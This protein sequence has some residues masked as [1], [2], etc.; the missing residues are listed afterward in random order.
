MTDKEVILGKTIE[1]KQT[2]A[3]RGTEAVTVEQGAT[4]ALVPFGHH[5]A[6]DGAINWELR[7]SASIPNLN[8][9]FQIDRFVWHYLKNNMRDRVLRAL[10]LSNYNTAKTVNAT[11]SAR[12]KF[13]RTL[14]SAL[15]T[16]KREFDKIVKTLEQYINKPARMSLTSFLIKPITVM[17][18]AVST[19]L[20]L[21]KEWRDRGDWEVEYKYMIISDK[22]MDPEKAGR[23]PGQIMIKINDDN[24]I[25]FIAEKYRP[26]LVDNTGLRIKS[27]LLEMMRILLGLPGNFL[28]ILEWLDHLDK[29]ADMELQ[30]ETDLRD[31]VMKR[32][33]LLMGAI[34]K[35]KERIRIQPSTSALDIAKHFAL[36]ITKS[37]I[38]K[39]MESSDWEKG[40]KEGGMPL[41]S[42]VIKAPLMYK[43]SAEPEG[44]VTWRAYWED[45]QVRI[46]FPA[47]GGEA[48]FGM[49]DI[50]GKADSTKELTHI[51]FCSSR[52]TE[53]GGSW[54]NKDYT[55]ISPGFMEYYDLKTGYWATHKLKI[56]RDGSITFI[57]PEEY[58][59]TGVVFISEIDEWLQVFYATEPYGD[60]ELKVSLQ[61]AGKGWEETLKQIGIPEAM[62]GM[63]YQFRYG[64]RAL[65][66]D[67][68]KL[69][70]K[71]K[72]F[73]A[74][75]KPIQEWIDKRLAMAK[76][77]RQQK[78][79]KSK[80]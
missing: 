67:Y 76:K 43:I 80:T 69:G 58:Q 51:Y 23:L 9:D 32:F 29:P 61:I 60:P 45:V 77:R 75:T 21:N 26:T 65:K 15:M 27:Q 42:E 38:T 18:S 34:S 63:S 52:F 74:M 19:V 49:P 10:S 3:W 37:I 2:L 68:E 12:N 64:G 66:V 55:T 47:E 62:A 36:E 57:T 39:T 17:I 35:A 54:Q 79:K 20:I 4:G 24:R 22:E 6:M 30:G 70:E 50:R 33:G 11:L 5:S 56:W 72:L 1:P 71:A 44:L 41:T 78:G 13:G 53:I 73:F 59:T 8:D 40:L 48:W 7:A 25:N 31:A 46:G 28:G 14:F 16:I